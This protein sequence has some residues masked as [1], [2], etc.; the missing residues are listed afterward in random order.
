MTAPAYARAL[1]DRRN[2]GVPTDSVFIAVGWPSQWLREFVSSFPLNRNA[3]ILA[4]PDAR[5]Y[6]YAV[7]LGLSVCVWYEQGNDAARAA[8][9]ASHVMQANPNRLFT[10]NATCGETQFYR[11]ATERRAAA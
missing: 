11:V 10:L 5:Q 7:T 8:V 2:R 3:V 6:D 4:T 1:I 9:I